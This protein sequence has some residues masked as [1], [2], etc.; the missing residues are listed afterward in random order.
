[1]STMEARGWIPLDVEQGNCV[2]SA[3]RFKGAYPVYAE[4]RLDK[5]GEIKG[6]IATEKQEPR[7]QGALTVSDLG[8]LEEAADTMEKL[9]KAVSIEPPA[10][11]AQEP[12][13]RKVSAS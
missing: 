9:L 3:W 11:R 10:V 13:L 1:M 8:S 7:I 12:E 6:Y 2:R 5:N 4:I